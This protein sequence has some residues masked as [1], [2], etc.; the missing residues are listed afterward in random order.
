[1]DQFFLQI[2]P[3]IKKDTKWNIFSLMSSWWTLWNLLGSVHGPQVKNTWQGSERSGLGP[4]GLPHKTPSCPPAGRKLMSSWG[5]LSHRHLRTKMNTSDQGKQT[6]AFGSNPVL[7]QSLCE[8]YGTQS[9]PFVFAFCMA[10]F[11]L[12]WQSGATEIIRSAEPKIL[13][14]WPFTESFP[15]PGRND[16]LPPQEAHCSVLF[17]SEFLR[18]REQ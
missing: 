3:N 9:H 5:S 17:N 13:T 14:L 18:H 12:Q 6:I 10:A 4:Y 15:T 1:M 16:L 11:R 7:H 8:F 2:L